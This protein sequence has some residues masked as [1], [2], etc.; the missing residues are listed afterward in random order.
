[1]NNNH[2]RPRILRGG[3]FMLSDRNDDDKE[4]EHDETNVWDAAIPPQ[5]E[6][7]PQLA[8]TGT[9]VVV[10]VSLEGKQE[11]AALNPNSQGKMTAG[12]QQKVIIIAASPVVPA[13][14]M[15]QQQE[16]PVLAEP[17]AREDSDL[18]D[19]DVE[20]EGVLALVQDSPEA[21]SVSSSTAEL[22]DDD[23][24]AINEPL[25][26]RSTAAAT[27][28]AKRKTLQLSLRPGRMRGDSTRDLCRPSSSSLISSSVV[29]RP[30]DEEEEQD[31]LATTMTLLRPGR[32]RG[33]SER[34][35]AA[36]SNESAAVASE[37][38]SHHPAP[39]TRPT[40]TS[41]MSLRPGGFRGDSYRNLPV[42][43]AAAAGGDSF[44][45]KDHDK[46]C[47]STSMRLGGV[48][49]GD[50]K[51]KL[52]VRDDSFTEKNVNKNFM[53]TADSSNTLLHLPSMSREDSFRIP[54]IGDHWTRLRTQ[55]DSML[56]Y[57]G[58]SER[59]LITTSVE[60]EDWR[61]NDEETMS[62]DCCSSIVSEDVVAINNDD[63]VYGDLHLDGDEDDDSNGYDRHHRN[64]IL[65][66]TNPYLITKPTAHTLSKSDA[67]ETASLSDDLGSDLDQDYSNSNI[68]NNAANRT[69]ACRD[70]TRQAKKKLEYSFSHANNNNND[71]KKNSSVMGKL[72]AVYSLSPRRSSAHP[73]K[74]QQVQLASGGPSLR[75]RMRLN[76]RRTSS[77]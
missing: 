57:Y 28:A 16:G 19:D 52:F 45:E 15:Q 2:V 49:R 40:T 22:S 47:F 36:A 68:T 24:E 9:V 7:E 41:T 32:Y 39:Q 18:V 67:E 25:C 10:G 13:P 3:S 75:Q 71:N 50:S 31:H 42:V 38:D 60:E 1:M 5:Q 14:P 72:A 66:I 77:S 17:V 65:Y 26:S 48:V 61:D 21:A 34:H 74:E 62:D 44:R 70:E 8:A 12:Y 69:S 58:A 46:S 29:A 27:A 53:S 63:N 64:D 51:R 20:A 6:E 23:A 55:D 30:Q 73:K 35:L 54:T 56:N 37:K 43:A 76:Q 11:A 33:D 4:K 59:S